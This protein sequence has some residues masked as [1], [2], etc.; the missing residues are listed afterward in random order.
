MPKIK[1]NKTNPFDK[2]IIW[3]TYLVDNQPKYYV[4]STTLRDMYYL[5]KNV[6]N[7]IS[8]TKYKSQNPIDLYKYMKG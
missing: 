2:E 6:E 1:A 7:T 3:L 8:K 5:Y 4:T